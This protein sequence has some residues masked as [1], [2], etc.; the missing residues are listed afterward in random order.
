MG[1]EHDRNKINQK[2][3]IINQGLESAPDSIRFLDS[4][5]EFGS[6]DEKLSEMKKKSLLFLF[7]SNLINPDP[8]SN[9][10]RSKT[11]FQIIENKRGNSEKI[12]KHSHL[13]L[14]WKLNVELVPQPNH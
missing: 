8:D 4:D 14:G 13:T 10:C 5:S 3:N 9:Q 6:R 7:F 1:L 11:M 2:L 12:N